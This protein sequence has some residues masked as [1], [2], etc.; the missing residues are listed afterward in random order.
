M[1]RSQRLSLNFRPEKRIGVGEALHPEAD[2]GRQ[3]PIAGRPAARGCE[4]AQRSGHCSQNRPQVRRASPGSPPRGQFPGEWNLG[5]E[6]IELGLLVDGGR[7][8]LRRCSL[9]RCPARAVLNQLQDRHPD[10]DLR[11]LLELVS[12]LPSITLSRT[13][14]ASTRAIATCQGPPAPEAAAMQ[15]R[16]SG[17]AEQTGPVSD[18]APLATVQAAQGC[19]GPASPPH[20]CR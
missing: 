5:A 15:P 2:D 20:G 16:K 4:L 17:V 14:R 10:V 11:K 12:R 6:G 9:G 19:P 1:G 3:G 7:S 13:C 8:R 18:P